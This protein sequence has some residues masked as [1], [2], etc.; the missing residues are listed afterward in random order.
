VVVTLKTVTLGRKEEGSVVISWTEP[1]HV[2]L[3]P[4]TSGQKGEK[5]AKLTDITLHYDC[6]I[7]DGVQESSVINVYNFGIFQGMRCGRGTSPSRKSLNSSRVS[8]PG[9][10]TSPW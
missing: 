6:D 1:W 8:D 4:T 2:S 10:V 7:Q 9:Q 5:E 3:F